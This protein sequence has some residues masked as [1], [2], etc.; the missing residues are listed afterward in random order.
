V[1]C[2]SL[3]SKL[4]DSHTFGS[5]RASLIILTHGPS[6]DRQLGAEADRRQ[7][8]RC[9]SANVAARNVHSSNGSYTA[10]ATE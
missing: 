2:H 5:G 3:E 1:V 6:V 10:W 7:W 4:T 9:T 8:P